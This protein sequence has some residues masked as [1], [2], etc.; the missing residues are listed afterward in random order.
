[1]SKGVLL[2]NL[3]SPDSTE[4]EDVKQYLDEFLM[5]ERVID[6]PFVLRSFIVR[7][8]ILRSRPAKTA[9][10]YKKIWWEEGSPLI[11]ITKR[12]IS[13]LQ[14]QLSLPME[15]AMRYGNPSI[16]YGLQQLKNKGVTDVLLLPLYPQYAM[17]TTETIEVLAEKLVKTK[18][19]EMK[20]TK[21]PAFYD[22][23][24]Y[25]EALTKVTKSHLEKYDFDHLLFSYHGVPE[26]HL[27]KTVKTK[28][29]KKITDHQ[30]CCQPNTEESKRCY[31]TH[32]FETTRQLVAQLGLEENQY[33]QSFQSRLG[34]DK[35]L[36]PF[37]SDKVVELAKSGVKKLAVITPAFVS[38][39]IETLE[40][41]EMEAGKEFLHNGGEE[42]K[43]IPCLNDDDMWVSA[44]AKWIRQWEKE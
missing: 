30:Y 17:A 2:V 32:C 24:E 13:K 33:S 43:M 27:Y 8:I 11:V 31:R 14:Q 29:H 26:R 21:F 3:G 15:M 5:D 42:F 16:E 28:N 1:M 19:K 10:A 23:P 9:K 6:F 41:I 38:D 39:C 20:L 37:T 36:E 7:G 22:R 35:W 44:L 40:E 18:F 25:I 34:I 12:L 4:V